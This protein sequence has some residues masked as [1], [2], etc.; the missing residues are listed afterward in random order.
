MA[1]KNIRSTKNDQSKPIPEPKPVTP[2]PRPTPSEGQTISK[3]GER[4]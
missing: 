2:A 4:K 1:N 3:G